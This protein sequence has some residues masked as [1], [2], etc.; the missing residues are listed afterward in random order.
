MVEQLMKLHGRGP[1][2]VSA[3]EIEVFL[4]Y[5]SSKKQFVPLPLRSANHIGVRGIAADAISLLPKKMR[6]VK[7]S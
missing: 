6:L 5:D 7:H 4:K 3:G 1:S 2:E